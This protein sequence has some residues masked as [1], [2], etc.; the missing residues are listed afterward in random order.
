MAQHISRLAKRTFECRL[1]GVDLTPAG[2]G[3]QYYPACQLAR[4]DIAHCK[5]FPGQL[6]NLLGASKESLICLKIDKPVGLSGSHIARAVNNFGKNVQ[7]LTI[8]LPEESE[9]E[10]DH[11]GKFSPE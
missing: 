11:K 4:V 7:M 2:S 6:D 3:N 1:W 8:L 10:M 9:S 5:L